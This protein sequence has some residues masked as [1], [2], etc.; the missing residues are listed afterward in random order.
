M[1]SNE[2]LNERKRYPPYNICN[3]SNPL[4]SSNSNNQPLN[5]QV[6]G[7]LTVS[8]TLTLKMYSNEVLNE[9]KGLFNPDCILA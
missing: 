5:N 6:L 2:V 7:L 8:V 1:Y 9:R 3:D 4:S